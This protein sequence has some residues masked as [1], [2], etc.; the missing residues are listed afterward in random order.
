LPFDG[1]TI[2]QG[3]DRI[4]KIKRAEGKVTEGVLLRKRNY[5]GLDLSNKF[6]FEIQH[7]GP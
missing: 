7:G 2:K 6:P 4:K 5:A 3:K 1:K